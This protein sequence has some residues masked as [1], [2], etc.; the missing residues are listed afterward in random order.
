MFG[1][2]GLPSELFLQLPHPEFVTL[3]KCFFLPNQAHF[4]VFSNYLDAGLFA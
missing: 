4:H 2:F 3:Y 1:H